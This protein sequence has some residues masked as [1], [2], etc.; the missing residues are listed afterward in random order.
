MRRLHSILQ[1]M[2][3][4]FSVR[5]LREKPTLETCQNP[6]FHPAVAFAGDGRGTSCVKHVP[7]LYSE[8]KEVHTY[9]LC[10]TLEKS[11]QSHKTP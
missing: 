2:E 6:W 7:R 9:V 11:Q 3:K 5:V 4:T 10:T 1:S 8:E